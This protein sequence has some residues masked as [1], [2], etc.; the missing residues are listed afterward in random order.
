MLERFELIEESRREYRDKFGRKLRAKHSRWNI[1]RICL[2]LRKKVII[3]RICNTRASGILHHV[4]IILHASY[5]SY[6][7]YRLGSIRNI[8]RKFD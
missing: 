1:V 6:A 4:W 8:V 2:Q 5:A 3:E 7:S